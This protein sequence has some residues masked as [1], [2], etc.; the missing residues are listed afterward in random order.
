MYTRFTVSTAVRERNR[1]AL[2]LAL[3]LPSLTTELPA[4]IPKV[5]RDKTITLSLMTFKGPQV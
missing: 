5:L 3:R 4:R 2:T 1:N